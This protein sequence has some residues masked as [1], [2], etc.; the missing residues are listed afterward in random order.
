MRLFPTK[1]VFPVRGSRFRQTLIHA[2]GLALVGTLPVLATPS[3]K[4]ALERHYEKFL[5]PEL[6]RCTTCHLP[7]DVKDPK[8]LDEFPHNPFGDRL[9]SLGEE[10]A[11]E[12]K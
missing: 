5:R 2:F 4:A 9:R 10:L 12:G 7:S 1:C 8:S 6:N 11:A 3:N